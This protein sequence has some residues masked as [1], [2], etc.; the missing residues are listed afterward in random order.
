MAPIVEP[1]DVMRLG[2][3]AAVAHP[4]DHGRC[5]QPL[6]IGPLITHPGPGRGP[7]DRSAG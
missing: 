4:L 7:G 2:V 5:N 6:T 3:S 1:D